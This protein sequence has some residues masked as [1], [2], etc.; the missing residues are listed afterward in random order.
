MVGAS[1]SAVLVFAFF[2]APVAAP[3][4]EVLL[5]PIAAALNREL[6]GNGSSAVRQGQCARWKMMTA[7]EW[8]KQ[9]LFPFSFI[10][11]L[12]NL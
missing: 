11:P 4:A 7:V 2:A 8:G 1:T 5:L 3:A 12:E 10:P 6:T 9:L